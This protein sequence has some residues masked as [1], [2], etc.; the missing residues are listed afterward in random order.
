[1]ADAAQPAWRQGRGR[2][3][4]HRRATG[5]HLRDRGR[6]A[7]TR[8]AD[9]RPAGYTRTP[10]GADPEGAGEE[11]VMIRPQRAVGWAS[12]RSTQALQVLGVMSSIDPP[13]ALA[14]AGDLVRRLEEARRARAKVRQRRLLIGLGAALVAIIFVVFVVPPVLLWLLRPPDLSIRTFT[15]HTK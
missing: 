1:V 14:P 4:H 8:R 15:G 7:A 12:L 2:E 6:A 5:D 13:W 9:H 10:A 3:R 11:A